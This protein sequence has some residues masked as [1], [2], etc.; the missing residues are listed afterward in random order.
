M[1]RSIFLFAILFPAVIWSSP[2]AESEHHISFARWIRDFTSQS[3][4][5]SPPSSFSSL[6]TLLRAR[7]ASALKELFWRDDG[8]SWSPFMMLDAVFR[9]HAQ[10][11]ILT[12]KEMHQIIFRPRAYKTVMWNVSQIPYDRVC[13]YSIPSWAERLSVCIAQGTSQNSFGL[14]NKER[15]QEICCC[16]SRCLILSFRVQECMTCSTFYVRLLLIKIPR[17]SNS[18]NRSCS[19]SPSPSVQISSS[20]SVTP[21]PWQCSQP[22]ETAQ[23]APSGPGATPF[24]GVPTF[25]PTPARSPLP[26]PSGSPQPSRQERP[27]KQKP[28]RRP[29]TS[30]IPRAGT[31]RP[32]RHPVAT[33]IM[34]TSNNK[35]RQSII[36]QALNKWSRDTRTGIPF[37]KYTSSVEYIGGRKYRVI[38]K[39]KERFAD[40]WV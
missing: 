32:S 19:A 28:S 20:P 36:S 1:K 37:W 35:K 23:D 15:E 24:E 22:T 34:I 7:A 8:K 9:Q 21:T 17:P 16:E 3:S 13:G 29:S 31:F 27:F 2:P 11:G 33:I 40:Q 26:R 18:N 30:P 6:L 4:P 25:L 10:K 5:I 12:C 38:F 39:F 14:Y